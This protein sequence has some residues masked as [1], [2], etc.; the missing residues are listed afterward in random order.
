MPDF[1]RDFLWSLYCRTSFGLLG[2]FVW[3]LKWIYCMLVT[4]AN[5]INFFW[6]L[7]EIIDE[8]SSHIASTNRNCVSVWTKTDWLKRHISF[9]TLDY[10]LVIGVIEYYV[11]IKTHR[12]KKKLIQWTE[13]YSLHCRFVSCELMN[14]L[15]S[16]LIVKCHSWV[17]LSSRKEVLVQERKLQVID[18]RVTWTYLSNLRYIVSCRCCLFSLFY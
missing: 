16:G 13:C 3:Q 8:H 2:D 1:F 10:D 11:F 5:F 12:R 17:I 6:R 4:S 15:T 9:N 18:A 7:S 14:L